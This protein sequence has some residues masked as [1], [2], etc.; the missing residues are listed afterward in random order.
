MINGNG[1]TMVDPNVTGPVVGNA[2]FTKE[3]EKT[4]RC[5][6]A[7]KSSRIQWTLLSMI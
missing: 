2:K 4:V 6:G 7:T 5:Q 1:C 3:K